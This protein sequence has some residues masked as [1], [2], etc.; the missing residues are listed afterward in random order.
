[1]MHQLGNRPKFS[2]VYLNPWMKP[3]ADF[4]KSRECVAVPA[5]NMP[6]LSTDS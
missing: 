5:K 1:M 2:P 3:P 4:R 6:G